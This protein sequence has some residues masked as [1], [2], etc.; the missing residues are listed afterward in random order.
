MT[1]LWPEYFTLN[2]RL[3]DKSRDLLKMNCAVVPSVT[4][5]STALTFTSGR[6]SSATLNESVD[7]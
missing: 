1:F 2:S 4:M 6:T 7:L 3:L 5:A